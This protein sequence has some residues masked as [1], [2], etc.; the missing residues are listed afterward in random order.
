[1]TIDTCDIEGLLIIQPKIFE[2]ERG[3]FF[4]SF[5]DKKF[6]ET[7]NQHTKFVQDNESFSGYGTLRGLHFQKPPHTQAKLVRVI[8]GKVLDVV[9]DIRLGSPTFGKHFS[10][11]LSE[12]NK[13]QLF[14]PGGFA[15]GFVV[16][17]ENALFSY[18]VDNYYNAE[19]DSGI[20]WNDEH[21]SV[22]WK[23]ERE[24]LIIS[25]KDKKQQSFKDYCLNKVF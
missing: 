13:T 1:V 18:K 23:I 9:V 4:E 14:V 19:S 15:H 17:S 6:Q 25:E 21:F 8:S 22:D 7:S 20:M 16:L 12:E 5:N 2:D 10:I 11:E 24:K 3:Y